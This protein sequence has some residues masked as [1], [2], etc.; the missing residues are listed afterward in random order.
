MKFKALLFALLMV[1]SLTFSQTCFAQKNISQSGEF[2]T[3]R[4]GIATVIFFGLG[5]AV[6]G[7]STLSFYGKPQ[8]NLQNISYGF[9]LG[10]IVGSVYVT[11]EAAKSIKED[12]ALDPIKELKLR[13]PQPQSNIA[14]FHFEF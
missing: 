8:E 3:A 11:A 4:R 2:V 12:M 1:F 14:Q 13:H 7:L 6:L 10:L 5:G 9:G